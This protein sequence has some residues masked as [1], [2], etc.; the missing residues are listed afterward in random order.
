MKKLQQCKSDSSSW[1]NSCH[2]QFSPGQAILPIHSPQQLYSHPDHHLLTVVLPWLK[3]TTCKTTPLLLLH[4]T[5]PGSHF[6]MFP[7]LQ[8][9]S[10]GKQTLLRPHQPP[11][12]NTPLFA[13]SSM[14]LP[15]IPFLSKCCLPTVAPEDALGSAQYLATNHFVLCSYHPST[16][17]RNTYGSATPAS[18]LL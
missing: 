1:R 3:D 12:A 10:S 2:F 6:C 11:A 5:P 13:S 16:S 17:P 8:A 14:F 7:S 4:L 9:P 18:G 15:S